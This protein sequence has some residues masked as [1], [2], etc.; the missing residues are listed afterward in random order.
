MKSG[1]ATVTFT[2]LADPTN[3][4]FSSATGSYAVAASAASLTVPAQAAI[5]G[6]TGNVAAGTLSL[7]ATAMPGIDTVTN[8]TAAS[9]GLDAEPDGALR[10]RF[11]N[12]ID[13]R[14]RATPAAIAYAI[15][16]LQQGLTHVLA[17][18]M[19]PSG[20]LRLGFFTV[21]VDDGTGSPPPITIAAVSAALEN[22]RPVGTQF[23]V[24]PPTLLTATIALTITAPA[25]SYATAQA[26]V[27]SAIK[28]YVSTLPIGASLPLSRLAAI[29][30]AADP[31][32]S[33]VSAITIN[34]AADLIAPPTSIIKPGTVTVD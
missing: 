10:T 23:A 30:Y 27:G 3:P 5:S 6:V 2:V 9:G 12:F 20:A 34:G 33:N 17:E 29:A 24:Q 1:D 15:Q 25:S 16:S 19:D 31:S 28:A 4:A 8:A 18:N 7:L 26:N 13:S 11:T 32:V 22:V 21:T 14:S